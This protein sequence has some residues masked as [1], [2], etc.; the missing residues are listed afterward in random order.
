MRG[1]GVFTGILFSRKLCPQPAAITCG[2][3]RTPICKLHVRP[4]MAGRFL[5]PSCDAYENDDDWR[6]SS[7][8]NGWHYRHTTRTS[9]ADDQAAAT[10]TGAAAGAAARPAAAD[11]LSD[12]DKAA[13]STNAAGAWQGPDDSAPDAADESDDGDFDAS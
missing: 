6:Y 11:D 1:C 10:A 13:L 3:C 9:R 8:D 2:R 5:C 12:E 4:Q 7:R